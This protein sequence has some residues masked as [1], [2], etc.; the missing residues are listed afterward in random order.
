MK[1]ERRTK[2]AKRQKMNY[3][4]M[5]ICSEI[6]THDLTELIDEN[7]IRVIVEEVTRNNIM[8]SVRICARVLLGET[9]DK[10]L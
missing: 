7:T 9:I 6:V 1:R 2:E 10:S 4:C 5:W 8:C 3:N